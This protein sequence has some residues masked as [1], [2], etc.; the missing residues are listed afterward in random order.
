MGDFFMRRKYMFIFAVIVIVAAGLMLYV[1]KNGVS[2][3][4]AS[5]V[6]ISAGQAILIDGSSGR[7]L[8]EK[9]PM[10]VHILPARLK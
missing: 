2:D 4:S 7:V 1:E 3:T 9:M 5:E 6:G 10:S 8:Y